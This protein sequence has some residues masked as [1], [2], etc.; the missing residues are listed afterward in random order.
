[1]EGGNDP[2]DQI[3]ATLR[4][5]LTLVITAREEQ[6]HRAHPPPEP[7]PTRSNE[8]PPPPPIYAPRAGDMVEF[9]IIGVGLVRGT[10]IGFTPKFTRIR[11]DVTSTIYLRTTAN[12]TIIHD[13][14]S[15]TNSARHARHASR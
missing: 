14:T 7:E 9:R 6:R 3:E 10:I 5:L 4:Q 8:A 12:I 11:R 1:M 15:A 13:G 2:Y